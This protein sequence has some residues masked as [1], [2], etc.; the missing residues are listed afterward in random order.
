MFVKNITKFETNEGHSIL[1]YIDMISP[2]C[3]KSNPVQKY[4]SKNDIRDIPSL[5]LQILLRNLK[6]YSKYKNT[7]TRNLL[8]SLSSGFISDVTFIFLGKDSKKKKENKNKIMY[9]QLRNIIINSCKK[10]KGNN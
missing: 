4:F 9:N 6:Y 1:L 10:Q 3:N 5:T 8:I 2:P 7:E